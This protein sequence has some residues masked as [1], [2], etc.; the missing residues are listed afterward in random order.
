MII[1]A[2]V[3]LAV[4]SPLFARRTARPARV[5][6]LGS[7]SLA[8]QIAAAL[9]A[10]RSRRWHLAGVV[11]DGSADARQPPLDRHVVGPLDRLADIIETVCPDRIVIAVAD[12]RGRLP[13]PVLLNARLQGI[14]VDDGVRF[15]ER[16]TGKIAIEALTPD[17]L[18]SSSSG[19]RQS[20][21]DAAIGRAVSV[22]VSAVALLLLAP[23]LAV[24]AAA[25]RLDS[26]GPVLFVQ[27]RIGLGGRRFALLKFRT[28]RPAWR[29][30]SEW[31]ET[32]VNVVPAPM[33][34]PVLAEPLTPTMSRM[35]RRPTSTVGSNCR[36][37]MFG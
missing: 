29:T 10:D 33:D 1:I 23:L 31:D 8:R 12:R 27:D 21:L 19:F 14:T 7:T 3:L 2:I 26:Q 34:T 11:D 28:M 32:A 22:V 35:P 37:F 15:F 17:H 5:L 13:M 20:M 6:V 4:I 9:T 30:I 18:V 25:I 36:R 16:V 24:I